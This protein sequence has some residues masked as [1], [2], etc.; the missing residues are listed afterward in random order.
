MY[1]YTTFPSP[2]HRLAHATCEFRLSPLTFSSK[3]RPIAQI[4]RQLPP[5]HCY[6]CSN[7]RCTGVEIPLP[8]TASAAACGNDRGAEDGLDTFLHVNG[9]AEVALLEDK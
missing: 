5:I 1:V 6:P 2:P 8:S 4:A 7:V 3:I 9:S